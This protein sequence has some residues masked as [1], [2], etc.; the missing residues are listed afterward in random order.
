MPVGPSYRDGSI[1]SRSSRP[2]S[3]LV[4]VTGIGRVCGTSA[5]SAP[6]VTTVPTPSRSA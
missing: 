5:S 2:S 1:A 4:L 6:S 3:S